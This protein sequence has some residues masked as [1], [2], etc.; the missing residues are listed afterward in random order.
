[1]K[2]LIVLLACCCLIFSLTVTGTV[3]N[4]GADADFSKSPKEFVSGIKV[5]WNLGNTFDAGW[6][7]N[8]LSNP[9][10]YEQETACGNPKTTQAIIAKVAESGFNAIRIPVS[11]GLQTTE[12]NGVYTV[13][14]ELFERLKEVI[15]LCYSYD[16]YVIIN[17][18]HDDQGWLNISVDDDE[19]EKIK[20][21]YRQIWEQIAD[22]F[23]YYNEKLIFEGANE[24]TATCVFD[25][26]G[27]STGKCWWG[28][29]TDSF[30]RL[31]ELYQI[32]VDT[33]RDSGGNNGEGQ[34]YLMLATYGAQW[35]NNQINH[36][37]IPNGDSHIIVD[38]HWYAA[39]DQ[40]NESTRRGFAN[41]W[42]S[43][44]NANNVGI[45]IGECGFSE[46]TSE[47]TKVS[48]AGSFVK[49][50]KDTYDIPVFLW[51]DG[52][53]MKIL[54]RKYNP[55][56]WSSN[57]QKY[58]AAV[59]EAVGVDT[60]AEDTQKTTA[61]KP[62]S[63]SKPPVSNV[64]G[65]IDNDGMFTIRDVILFRR[66]LVNLDLP[67]VEEMPETGDYN[68]DGYYNM[69]DVFLMRKNLAQLG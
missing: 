39:S 12:S 38:I 64:L 35:Y 49:D 55:P 5:G 8:S 69:K 31:N 44:S 21:K 15:S 61:T 29:S 62:S 32:F 36:L 50:L 42:K 28:H 30:E 9:S 23:K 14:P 25:G 43:F 4:A 17:M 52:G 37:T 2:K 1:M 16:M 67:D 53:N 57:S 68:G 63:T 58:I 3:M 26:C 18:H 34:R 47:T 51:D 7:V 40:M 33:V 6:L 45:V 48:W 13:N 19:W 66:Y 41:T 59:M 11:W 65:D 46:S 60:N 54:E 27:T 10:I 20:E 56:A 22:S 24:V